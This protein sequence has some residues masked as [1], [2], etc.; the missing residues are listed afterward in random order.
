MGHGPVELVDAS[1]G[2]PS[3]IAYPDSDLTNPALPAGS[4]ITTP[5]GVRLTTVSTGRT[6]TFEVRFAEDAGAPA[7]PTVEYAALLANGQY[8]VHWQTP[9]DNGQ[10]VLGYEV[11]AEPSGTVTFVRSPAAYRTSTV[12]PVERHAPAQTFTVKAVNQAGWS[13]VSA[14][15]A[16]AAYGPDVTITSP[17]AQAHVSGSFE[18]TFL[19][20]ADEQTGARPVRGWV[21]ADGATCGAVDGAGPYTVTCSGLVPGRAHLSVNVVNADGVTTAVPLS[22][23]VQ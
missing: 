10:I 14:P 11:T 5:E 7:A 13:A 22:L 19:A 20:T 4:S 18:V 8:R 15:V 9:A 3:G 6:A 12:V 17:A 16:G 2:N 1:P 23:F 21:E